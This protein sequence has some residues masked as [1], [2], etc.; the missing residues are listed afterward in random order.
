MNPFTMRDCKTEGHVMLCILGP[1][2][3]TGCVYCDHEET[4]VDFDALLRRAR[5]KVRPIIDRR[6]E[7]LPQG[8]MDFVLD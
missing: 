1:E 7:S 4:R 6:S 2:G 3:L 5:E 8:L